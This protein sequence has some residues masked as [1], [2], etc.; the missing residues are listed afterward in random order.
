[1]IC[2]LYFL[3]EGTRYSRDD[4]VSENWGCTISYKSDILY[5]PVKETLS[6]QNSFGKA[7][8]RVLSSCFEWLSAM[9]AEQQNRLKE[10]VYLSNVAVNRQYALRNIKYLT[11]SDKHQSLRSHSVNFVSESRVLLSI[12]IFLSGPWNMSIGQIDSMRICQSR[13]VDSR[14]S[15]WPCMMPL[16][17]YDKNSVRQMNRIAQT[18]MNQG[19]SAL[20]DFLHC[21]L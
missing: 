19:S 17:F 8:C 21:T 11:N 15:G 12:V 10:L 14:T 2:I 18:W 16:P 6:I 7:L 5:T 3:C 20:R 1:M 9:K 13:R 4:R